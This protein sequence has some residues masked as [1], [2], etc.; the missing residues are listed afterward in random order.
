[1]AK[2]PENPCSI[3]RSLG[4]LGERWTFLILRDA[5]EGITRFADFRESLGVAADV[6]SDRLATLVEYG[7]LTKVDYQ[8]PGERRRAAYELTDAGRELFV[9]IAA[10]QEWGDRNLPWAEGPSLL[11]RERRTGR[12]VHVGFLD[13]K[14][15]PVE[16]QDVKF[17]PTK[18]YPPERLAARRQRRAG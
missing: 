8:D 16:P 11:R 14:G 5:F 10:L 12:A 4:V 9:V 17:V 2:V 18:S 15:Q 13:S 1:M 6:L 7:V 3:A